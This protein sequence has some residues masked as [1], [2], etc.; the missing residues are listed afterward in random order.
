MKLI[1]VFTRKTNLTPI[2]DNVRFGPPGL[3]DDA[4]EIHISNIFTWDINYAHFLAEQWKH[5][6]KVKIGGP[7]YNLPSGNFIPGL[8]VRK[9][10]IIT[11]RG[12][13]NKCWF[14][15]V[16]KR[17][18]GIKELPITTGYNVLD[19]NLLACSDKHIINVFNM[20]KTQKEKIS[21]TGGLEAK[22]FKEWHINLLLKLN[23]K[24][25]FFAYDTKDDYEPLVNASK[26]LKKAGYNRNKLRCYCLIGYPKDTLNNAEN[27]LIQCLQLG[28]YPM[29]MLW[30]DNNEYAS[31]EWR[32][33]QRL[34]AR[35]ANIYY[36]EK[37]HLIK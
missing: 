36:Y 34:W 15:S 11:S 4:D 17:E 27:R 14:C 18:N 12:C 19:D 2:D 22:I 5:I 30:K 25:M 21:F 8:Y 23:I 31:R 16:W 3:F 29:A 9:G 7:A 10:A 6:G 1:R 26:L 13:N 35:P 28:F 37:K 33:F 24:Q 32:Q 20:L